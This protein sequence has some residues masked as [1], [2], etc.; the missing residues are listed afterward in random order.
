MKLTKEELKKLQRY[1]NKRLDDEGLSLV[2]E[3]DRKGH[4]RYRDS[5]EDLRHIE[6]HYYTILSGYVNDESTV[7]RND[8]HRYVLTRHSQGALIKH[9][10]DELAQQGKRR[11]RWS[12]RFIIRR[13][14]MAWKIRFYNDKQLNVK[15]YD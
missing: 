6:A 1:W 5:P 9:I 7:F 10:V 14:E 15:K 4:R 11:N 12:V 13:Y 2:Q 3:I 8:I